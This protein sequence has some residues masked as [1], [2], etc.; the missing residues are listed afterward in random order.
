M[1]EKTMNLGGNAVRI[2]SSYALDFRYTVAHGWPCLRKHPFPSRSFPEAAGVN[3]RKEGSLICKACESKA[4]FAFSGTLL[5]THVAKY[6]RCGNCG[7]L[8]TEDPV[9][10]GPPVPNPSRSSTREFCKEI[11]C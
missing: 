2:P 1:S 10:L 4:D 8:F 6:F 3:D 11:S 9:W 5:E 7:F